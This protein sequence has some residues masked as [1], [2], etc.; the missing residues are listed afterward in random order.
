MV[1][2]EFPLRQVDFAAYCLLRDGATIVRALMPDSD[3]VVY[4]RRE[5]SD[6]G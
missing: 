1:S 5:V 2:G 3:I 6:E 4:R